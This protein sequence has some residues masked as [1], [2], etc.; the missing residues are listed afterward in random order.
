M[1]KIWMLAV[2]AGLLSFST[3]SHAKGGAGTGFYIGLGGSVAVENFDTDDLDGFMQDRGGRGVEVENEWGING[4]IGY[5]F[6]PWFA[7]EF[8]ID[9]F[10]DFEQNAG[11]TRTTQVGEGDPQVEVF[12]QNVDVEL[13]TCMGVAKFVDKF[14]SARPFVC[15]GLGY[16]DVEADLKIKSPAF[17]DSK[18]KNYNGACGKLGL[19]LDYLFTP[20]LSLGTEVSY[21][22]GFGDVNDFAYLY[23][24]VLN[25][26]LHF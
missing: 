22:W 19:G 14:Y 11:S 8:N 23:W 9:Y 18:T 7:L 17:S 2:I 26:A 1:K 3:P 24:Q 6:Q 16:M 25:V 5:F 4:K 12:K 20:H 10:S 21:V 13:I 15:V